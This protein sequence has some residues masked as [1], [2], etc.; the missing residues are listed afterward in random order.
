VLLKAIIQKPYILVFKVNKNDETSAGEVYFLYVLI[1]DQFMY[2]SK[3]ENSMMVFKLA[4]LI[5]KY[6]IIN[7]V[8]PGSVS[9]MSERWRRPLMMFLSCNPQVPADRLNF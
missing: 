1:M 3:M 6:M 4:A 2:L 5:Y 8:I 7:R 9:V